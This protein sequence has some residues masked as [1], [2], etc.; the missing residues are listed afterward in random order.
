MII[1][2][3]KK[4]AKYI[5]EASKIVEGLMALDPQAL[6]NPELERIMQDAGKPKEYDLGKRLYKS[7]VKELSVPAE[8]TMAKQVSGIVK[9]V[10]AEANAD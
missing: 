6:D 8:E 10:R 1:D 4:T 2:Y 5:G 3:I 7:C 9:I